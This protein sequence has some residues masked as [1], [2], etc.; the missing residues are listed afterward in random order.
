MG[1]GSTSTFCTINSKYSLEY[2][3][4]KPF[5]A[6]LRST[7]KH[8]AWKT[9]TKN[10]NQALEVMSAE[11]GQQAEMLGKWNWAPFMAKT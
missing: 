10:A 6:I 9:I 11:M 1:K 2:R 3:E 5:Q 8:A 4:V 7:F